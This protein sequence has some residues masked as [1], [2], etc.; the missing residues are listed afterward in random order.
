MAAASLRCPFITSGTCPALIARVGGGGAQRFNPKG[1]RSHG[2][3]IRR[4]DCFVAAS[5]AIHQTLI[6][7]GMDRQRVVTVYEGI[8]VHRSRPRRP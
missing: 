5:E 8:D 1:M 7:D 4:V 6:E 2:G 3:N